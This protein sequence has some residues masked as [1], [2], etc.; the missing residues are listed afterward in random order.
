MAKKIEPSLTTI[1]NYLVLD[2]DSIFV[3]PEYQR[4]YSWDIERCDKLWQD[5]IDYINGGSKDHYFFGTIIVNCREDDTKFDL[6]DGQ[7]RTT[8]FL[9]LLKALLINID[10]QIQKGNND[11]DSEKLIKGLKARRTKIIE[12]LYRAAIEDIPDCQQADE[13]KDLCN[14]Y[15]PLLKNDSINEL[16]KDEL[17]NILSSLTFEEAEARVIKIPRKQNDNK[18]TNYFRNFKFYY[19]K[20][21]ELSET[22]L[23]SFAKNVLE[24]CEVIQIKSWQVDQAITMFNSLN[25]DGMPLYDS[26]IISAQFYANAEKSGNGQLFSEKWKKLLDILNSQGT[27]K[28]V[29]ID[30]I[31]MQHMYYTRTS[32][33]ETVSGGSV[34]VTTPGL[35]RYFL[36]GD[37]GSKALVNDPIGQTDLIFNLA[38]IWN[39]ASDSDNTAIKTLLK[40]N[41]NSKLYL[42][43][44]FY[45]FDGIEKDDGSKNPALCS[46]PILKKDLTAIAELLMR[47]FAILELVDTGYSSSKFK[48]FLFLEETKLIDENIPLADINSDFSSHIKSNWTPKEIYS[49]LLDSEANAFVFLNEYLFSKELNFS[50]TIGANYDIEHIMPSSGKNLYEI[51]KD[52]GFESGYVDEFKNYVNKLGNKILLESKINRSIG[53]EWFRTKISKDVNTKTGYKNSRFPLAHYLVKKYENAIKPFWTK[54]DIEE[55]TKKAAER[56]THFIF[57]DSTLT[58]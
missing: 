52:A 22:N 54:D 20:A 38:S 21:S 35:R 7:Q 6:I 39:F 9:L 15:K 25:S 8:T 53:N 33:K 10:K 31:L 27:E 57:D 44:Y 2:Q 4:A 28:L 40:F 24:N 19:E 12:I 11:E 17:T 46:K 48:S 49:S 32:R 41:E 18:Y 43:S 58:F 16:Y 30:S 13:Y 3:V 45:R 56:I 23:N 36:D 34:N 55:E 50:Y 42:G 29:D 1:G 26:D 47:I 5:I 14:G 51:Q 37:K